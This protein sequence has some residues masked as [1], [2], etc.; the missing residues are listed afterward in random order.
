MVNMAQE[1]NE[2]VGM[3]DGH[4]AALAAG[5]S[6]GRAVRH[7]LEALQANKP[8]RGRKRTPDSIKTRLVKIEREMQQVSPL[9]QLQ[10]I[11]ERMD[12][13]DELQSMSE[14]IDITDLEA[15]FIRVA[16]GYS[17]RKKISY[18]AWREMGVPSATLSAAGISRGAS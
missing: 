12:L 9:K 6:E 10:L 1:E 15:E 8:K 17:E 11:Q 4:K 5:R 16:K 7:Y 2:D 13:E 18:R 3:S 14:A